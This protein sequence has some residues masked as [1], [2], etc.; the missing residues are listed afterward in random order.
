MASTIEGVYDV[1]LN[2]ATQV[3]D[4]DDSSENDMYN[5]Y[6]ATSYFFLERLFKAFPFAQDD[7]MVDF[8]CGKGRVLFMASQH[9]CKYATG[10]ENNKNRFKILQKNVEQ[11]RQK[12]GSH[13]FFNIS[14]EDAQSAVIDDSANKFFFFEPFHLDIYAQVVQ[15][16]L[17]SI[18]RKQRDVTIFLYLPQDNTLKY[19]DT[20]L[21]FH[22]EIYVDS[23]LYYRSDSLVTMPYFAFYGNYSM[24][25]LVDPYFLMY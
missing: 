25:N 24:E 20:I 17:K 14:D 8:G 6:E 16:I 13:T 7:R 23:T 2:V 11:Y 18:D 22:K 19:F 5:A 10:Y 4:G 3:E 15:N 9:S 21:G 12:N 1:Y